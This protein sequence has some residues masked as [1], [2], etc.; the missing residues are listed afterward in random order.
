[1]LAWAWDSLLLLLE[2]G[3][4]PVYA[5]AHAHCTLTLSCPCR[6]PACRT[7]AQRLAAAKEI[8]ID[9]EAHS[10]RSFQVCMNEGCGLGL[11][12]MLGVWGLSMGT[13]L[14]RK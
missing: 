2:L 1:M 9:L 6:R 3:P 4:P 11:R 8:A 7:A 5:A 12:L 10:Y 13:R 14:V